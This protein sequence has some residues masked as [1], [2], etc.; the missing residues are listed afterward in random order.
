MSGFLI[1]SHFGSMGNFEVVVPS[2]AAGG[3]VHFWR[4]ND[5]PSFP[6]S[7]PTY[8]AGGLGAID[9]VSL[10]ESN[11][12]SPGNLEVVAVANGQLNSLLAGFFMERSIH[13]PQHRWHCRWGTRTNSR[14]V[15]YARQLRSRRP[16]I[17][18][19][20]H[21]LLAEQ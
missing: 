2:R 18:W 7:G 21:P 14:Y 4:N 11:F 10:I 20:A 5:D 12:G 16:L 17:F 3:L 19:R 15:W 13:H 6:W 9:G 8:F 1:Q